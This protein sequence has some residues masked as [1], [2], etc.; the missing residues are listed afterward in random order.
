MQLQVMPK[1]ATSSATVLVRPRE[2]VL[3]GDVGG[4]ERRRH[5]RMGRCGGNDAAPLA[6][7]HARYCGANGVER[8]RQIGGD[9]LIPLLDREFLDRRDVLN[10]GIVHQ[11]VERAERLL[12]GLD[13]GSDLVGLGHVSTR[14]DRLDADSCSMP[15]RNFSIA[16]ASPKP[17]RVT[18]APWA[19]NALAMERPMPDVDPVTRPDFPFS[20]GKPQFNAAPAK[21]EKG[22]LMA[23]TIARWQECGVFF[24]AVQYKYPSGRH[25]FA[26]LA[27][28]LEC[29][30]LA[31]AGVVMRLTVTTSET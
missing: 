30:A 13:H 21:A 8:R 10:A 1:V 28:G 25:V 16:A 15:A 12:A 9:D 7:F 5:Q 31:R 2:T 19:A 23:S 20:M 11:D 4:L 24:A 27:D 14:V 22:R 17:L 29:R 18:L 6:R 3:G 26:I